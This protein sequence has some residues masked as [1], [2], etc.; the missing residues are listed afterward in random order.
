MLLGN[1]EGREHLLAIVEPGGLFGEAACF[2]GLPYHT[3][4]VTVQP[5]TVRVFSRVRPCWRP[6]APSPT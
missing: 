6:C 3:T 4:T 2:D 5:C 1:T